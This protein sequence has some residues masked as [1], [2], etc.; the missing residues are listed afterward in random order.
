MA[1]FDTL[2]DD[3]ASRYGLGANARSLIKE[4]LAMISGSPGGLGGFLDKFKSAGLTSEVASWLGRPDASPLAAGQ[5]ERALGAT[6]LGAIASR[7]GL[8]QGAASTALGYALPKIVG[9]LT[10]GGVVPAGV[11]AE[12]TT[13]LSQPPRAAAATEQVAPRRLDVYP[14]SRRERILASGAGY[15]RRSLRWSSSRSFPISGRPSTG[16]RLL[17]L[18][19]MRRS[20]RRPRRRPS[21]KRRPRR[22]PL[23]PIGT[24]ANAA[25]PPHARPVAQ[26]RLRPPPSRARC[27]AGSSGARPCSFDRS[28]G[29]SS[30]G[31]ASAG[32]TSACS[33]D[34]AADDRTGACNRG[35]PS[36]SR[37]GR[38]NRARVRLRADPIRAQQRQWRRAGF[39]RRA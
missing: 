24:S 36:G 37:N 28:A 22:L 8:A 13:F 35:D 12:V 11:P 3:L 16:C 23:A 33:R 10:P 9:L 30:A 29:D 34:L 4:V 7:L 39:G 25:A 15:G 14:A 32:N 27:S 17:R 18:S 1:T 31:F 19:P 26:P 20:R 2:I 5:V 6:A 21:H 38:T